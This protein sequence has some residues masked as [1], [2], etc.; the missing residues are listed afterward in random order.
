MALIP[1]RMVLISCRMALIPCRMALIP[2]RMALIPC[3]MALI[4]C[5]MALIPGHSLAL[6][7]SL[8][9]PL[10]LTLSLS[11]EKQEERGGHCTTGT[12]SSAVSFS[13]VLLSRLTK[14]DPNALLA[15]PDETPCPLPIS[16]FE[17]TQ[18]SCVVL[19]SRLTKSD[20]LSAVVCYSHACER[21]IQTPCRRSSRSLAM[22]LPAISGRVLIIQGYLAHKTLNPPWTLR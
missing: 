13:A 11:Q 2:C 17:M 10:Y 16:V 22:N 9:P 18:H 8:S 3:R 6:S 14:S 20:S 4:P 21:V 19:R 7:L 15:Q 5:R 1:C 12:R